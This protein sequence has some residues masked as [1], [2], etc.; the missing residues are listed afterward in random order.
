[1]TTMPANPTP[2]EVVVV[3]LEPTEEI[4]VALNK[5]CDDPSMHGDDIYRAFI[6]LAARPAAPTQSA[7]QT[8]EVDEAAIGR[9]FLRAMEAAAPEYPWLASWSPAESYGE[10]ITDLLALAFPDTP[11]NA[12]IEVTYEVWQDDMMV[13]SSSSEAEAVHYAFVYGQDGPVELKKAVTTRTILSQQ[14][15]S[16]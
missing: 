5:W 4:T 3:P 2:A 8:G 9:D 15:P 13:A 12:E 14:E 16:Q 10:L 7:A 11:K 6:A 1:M